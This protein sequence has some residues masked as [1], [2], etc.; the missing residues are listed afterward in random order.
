[1]SKP[2]SSR[3]EENNG[4]GHGCTYSDEE[5]CSIDISGYVEK[6]KQFLNIPNDL[7]LIPDLDESSSLVNNDLEVKVK[8]EMFP[9][10]PANENSQY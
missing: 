7:M 10:D 5:R 6:G 8:V 4:E 9:S 1:V 2:G 3:Y